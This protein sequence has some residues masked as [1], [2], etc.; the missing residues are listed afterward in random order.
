MASKATFM[1]TL[2]FKKTDYRGQQ[3]AGRT[4]KSEVGGQ[5]AEVRGQKSEVRGH[6]AAS[7]IVNLSNSQMFMNGLKDEL[8]YCQID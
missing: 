6:R 5:R 2:S 4:Q 7:Q 1:P 8:T 3:E